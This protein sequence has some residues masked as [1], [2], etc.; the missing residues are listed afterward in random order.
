VWYC[1]FDGPLTLRGVLHQRPTQGHK[2]QPLVLDPFEPIAAPRLP[3]AAAETDIFSLILDSW[4]HV[5]LKGIRS[6]WW[7]PNLS[8]SILFD[9][10]GYFHDS[11]LYIFLYT[12]PNI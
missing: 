7:Q 10:A 3:V 12:I 11:L 4:C 9:K 5:N 6:A 8:D 2:S 1:G